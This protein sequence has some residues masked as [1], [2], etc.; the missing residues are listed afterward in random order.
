MDGMLNCPNDL[1]YDADTC[2]VE[3]V[4]ERPI[5]CKCALNFT[6]NTSTTVT[7][8]IQSMENE[9]NPPIEN[10]L[11]YRMDDFSYHSTQ[12]GVDQEN[13]PNFGVEENSKVN[14][15]HVVFNLRV[16][17]PKQGRSFEACNLT[18]R[19]WYRCPLFN[20]LVIS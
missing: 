8:V 10:V 14:P 17:L 2:E 11:S 13:K 5:S 3:L 19:E 20:P 18:P 16:V 15:L 7:F 6:T 9:P 12:D 4:E 1:T